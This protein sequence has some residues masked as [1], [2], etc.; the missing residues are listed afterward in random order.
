MRTRL[1]LVTLAAIFAML[2][3]LAACGSDPAD[4]APD[5]P[6]SEV[7]AEEPA[8]D[9]GDQGS[10]DAAQDA[11]MYAWADMELTDVETGETFTISELSGTPV[12]IQSFAVW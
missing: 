5:D 10:G 3:T 2:L 1:R 11:S 6:A 7:P 12:Y 4:Q 8:G 9:S